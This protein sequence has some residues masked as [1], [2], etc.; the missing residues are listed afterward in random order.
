MYRT[1]DASFWTDQKVRKLT[2]LDRLLFLYLITNPHTHVSGLY[3]LPSLIAQH[4][5][6][7]SAKQLDTLSHT[8]SS[9]GIVLFD[10]VNELVWVVK[11]F[12]FQGKGQKNTLSAARHIEND[13]HNSYLINEFLKAYPEVAPHV[14]N[15]VSHT[16]SEFGTPHS[17]FPIPQQE[18]ENGERRTDGDMRASAPQPPTA[19]RKSYGEFGWVK[20]TDEEHGKLKAKLNGQIDDYIARFDNWVQQAPDAKKDGVKRRDRHPYASICAWRTNDLKGN[21][22]G[23]RQQNSGGNQNQPARPGGLPSLPYTPK[24]R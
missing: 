2:P 6:G 19:E 7:L 20:L 11:M 10:Q 15:R 14:K 23:T 1:I 17:P 12:R 18:Q 13:V 24:Q 8:L 21:P 3:Y 4:E 16:L 5:T 22:N 9:A